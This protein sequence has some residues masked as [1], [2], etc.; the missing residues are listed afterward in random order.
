MREPHQQ[1]NNKEVLDRLTK[2]EKQLSLLEPLVRQQRSVELA[3]NKVVISCSIASSTDLFSFGYVIRGNKVQP[4]SYGGTLGPRT[5]SLEANM[6]CIYQALTTYNTLKLFSDRTGCKSLDIYSTCTE[7]VNLLNGKITT[8][9][10]LLLKKINIIRDEVKA[11]SL[12][13]G[14]PIRFIRAKEPT[15]DLDWARQL[16]TKQ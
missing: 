14:L 13:I 10:P 4:L 15:G 2:L 6:D 8:K 1:L 3:K 5:S 9:S 16:A 7:L 12:L 11:L